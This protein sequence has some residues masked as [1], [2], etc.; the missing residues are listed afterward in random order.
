MASITRREAEK[1]YFSRIIV[2]YMERH[3]RANVAL[4]AK[5]ALFEERERGNV[6][7]TVMPPGMQI[8]LTQST[9]IRANERTGKQPSLSTAAI[10]ISIKRFQ[11]PNV[12]INSSFRSS[13]KR[14]I[15]ILLLLER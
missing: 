3:L 12:N 15:S 7:R 6:A 14:I 9:C 8:F 10:R 11:R 13:L 2:I 4:S 1:V 5:E